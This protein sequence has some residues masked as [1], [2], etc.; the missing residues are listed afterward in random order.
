MTINNPPSGIDDSLLDR[1]PG[2]IVSADDPSPRCVSLSVV[3]PL[4]IADSVAGYGFYWKVCL[5]RG[6]GP[7]AIVFWLSIRARDQFLSSLYWSYWVG[8]TF[9]SETM[10]YDLI[11]VS[12]W[13]DDN[14]T[15][16]VRKES[17]RFSTGKE[18]I[19]SFFK[20]VVNI[21]LA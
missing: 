3:V 17:S 18:A 20:I 21:M 13:R 7:V 19:L 5:G 2:R 14:D 12:L 11:H 9:P 6:I 8:T 1:W 16:V 15:A 4:V 10:C